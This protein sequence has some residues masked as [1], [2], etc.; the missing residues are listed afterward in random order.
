MKKLRRFEKE[1]EWRACY[2]EYKDRMAQV[3]EGEAYLR[4]DYSKDAVTSLIFGWN[5]PDKRRIEIINS[6]HIYVRYKE[7]ILEEGTVRIL[8]LPKRVSFPEV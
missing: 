6:L 7:A 1:K 8:D 4:Y 2:L 3:L 5:M